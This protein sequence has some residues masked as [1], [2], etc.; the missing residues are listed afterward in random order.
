MTTRI[1][2]CA[3][4]E[5]AA[6]AA[7]QVK[8]NGHAPFAVFNVDGTFYVTEDTCTHGKASLGDEGEL[9]GCIVTCTWHD[10]RFDVRTGEPCAMPCTKAIRT[11]PVT[12]AEESV[13]IDVEEEASP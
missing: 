12:V 4:G 3:I 2:L 7:L 13:W 1:R 5:V 9:N 8:A 10:G 11:F 6:G